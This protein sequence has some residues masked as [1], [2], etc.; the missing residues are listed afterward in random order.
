VKPP[1]VCVRGEE[2]P[3]SADLTPK[4][5]KTPTATHSGS[6]AWQSPAAATAAGKSR[7]TTEN[8]PEK[9]E[10]VSED[11]STVD[12]QPKEQKNPS[13]IHNG[14]TA[15][16]KTTKKTGVGR[17]SSGGTREHR[18]NQPPSNYTQEEEK[19]QAKRLKKKSTR[20]KGPE[21]EEGGRVL[22]PSLK[23]V[24]TGKET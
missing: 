11:P 14:A 23:T 16:N 1:E 18:K 13:T 5:Q 3:N 15:I 6:G 10:H 17:Q 9:H 20:R 2:D 24:F 12:L 7:T 22:P 21:E 8:P 19:P 4:L